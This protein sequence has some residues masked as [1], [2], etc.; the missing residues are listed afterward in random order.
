GRLGRRHGGRACAPA[1]AAVGP[2]RRRLLRRRLHR[3][4]RRR[5]ATPRREQGYDAAAPREALHMNTWLLDHALNVPPQAGE[6]GILAKV[7]ERLP[8]RNRWC[9]EFGA[10]DGEHY[11]NTRNLVVAEGYSAVLIE[12][13]AGR[14][15]ELERRSRANGRI[16]PVKAFVGFGPDD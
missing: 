15:A 4:R 13:D 7:L 5:R 11:S 12:A 2:R 10:W 8:D 6:D 1:H 16:V 3:L 9:V 14:Y